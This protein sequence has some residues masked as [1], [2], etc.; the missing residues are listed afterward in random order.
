MIKQLIEDITFDRITLSQALT[1]A[2]II[3]YKISNTQFK[4]WITSEINGYSADTEL[5]PYRIIPCDIF[6]EITNPY[7]GNDTI[8]FDVTAL[9]KDLNS[10]GKLSLYVMNVTQSIPT[11]EEGA[12]NNKNEVYVCE[13]L[14]QGLVSLLKEIV[15]GE[16]GNMITSVK[17]RIQF[18]Q[19]QHIV[20]TTKQRLLDTLLKL[21]ATFPNLENEYKNDSYNEAKAQT[22]INQHIYG[23]YSNSNIGV[24]ENVIQTIETTSKL[25]KLIDEIKSLG[26]DESDAKE[27]KEIILHE[28]RENVGKK[29]MNW[30]GKMASKAV[31]KGIKLQV[32]V[33]IEKINE[34]I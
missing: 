14:P 23:D 13:Y 24:G 27:V 32:P 1:R 9:D 3:A 25:D 33:L 19:V 34:F 5:P 4:D 18:S 30:V 15:G 22:I 20:R 2:K 28:K 12:L 10:N 7:K 8:P 31:E 29:I 11:L 16:D 26:I 6:A 17:R 21:N